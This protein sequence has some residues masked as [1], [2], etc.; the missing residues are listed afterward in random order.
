MA[1][2]DLLFWAFVL[3]VLGSSSTARPGAQQ[4]PPETAPT[5]GNIGVGWWWYWFPTSISDQYQAALDKELR[6]ARRNKTTRR[7]EVRKTIG[8]T[9]LGA[10]VVVF[11]CR[12]PFRWELP[13]LPEPA[14]RGMDTDLTDVAWAIPAPPSEL[15]RM[16]EEVAKQAW[17]YL[18]QLYQGT[19]PPSEPLPF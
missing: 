3:L 14:P 12:E 7:W 8:G 17:D 5:P 18:R 13:G 9:A 1:D 11:Y 15:R 4:L 16:V 19:R 10:T 6:R 2:R